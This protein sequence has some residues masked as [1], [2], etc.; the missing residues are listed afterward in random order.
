MVTFKRSGH[1][2]VIGYSDSDF[3]GCVDRRKS[4]L[5]YVFLLAR[6]AISWKSA[7]QLVVVSSTMEAKFVACCEATI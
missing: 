1:L 6:G 5:G 2:E 4:T 7:K 3:V